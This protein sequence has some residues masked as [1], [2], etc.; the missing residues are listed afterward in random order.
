M[1]IRPSRASDEGGTLELQTATVKGISKLQQ[2]TFLR[3]GDSCDLQ[4][5]WPLMLG[6]A[7]DYTSCPACGT[8]VGHESLQTELHVCDERHRDDHDA[9]L[10]LAEAFLFDLEWSEYLDSPHGRFEMFYAARTRSA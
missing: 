3:Y 2:I 1:G 9:S 10:A 5:G 8:S 4:G 7:S 6:G